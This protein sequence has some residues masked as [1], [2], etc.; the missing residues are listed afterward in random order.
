[1][2]RIKTKNYNRSKFTGLSIHIIPGGGKGVFIICLVI[3]MAIMW[4][5]VLTGQKPS[6]AEAASLKK[7]NKKS[8]KKLKISYVKLPVIPGRNDV[9]KR[10]FFDVKNFEN[11]AADAGTGNVSVI[12]EPSV[13]GADTDREVA[14]QIMGRLSLEAIILGENPHVFINGRIYSAGDKI[15][16]KDRAGVYELEVSDIAEKQ[17]FLKYH[18]ARIT[19]KLSDSETKDKQ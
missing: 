16:I 12:T 11:F 13:S 1:M 9:I 4:V 15:V 19:L 3:V 17:V 10:D 2:S 14:K 18:R 7:T 6:G 8:S 5:R